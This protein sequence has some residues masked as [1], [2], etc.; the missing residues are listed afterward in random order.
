MNKHGS[1]HITAPERGV[2]LDMLKRDC[3]LKDIALAIEKDP[4]AVSREIR[5]RRLKYKTEDNFIKR[6]PKYEELCKRLTRFPF[7]C[8]GCK[9]RRGC[10]YKV[11]FV[12]K[13]EDAHRLYKRLLRDSRQGINLTPE[14]FKSLDKKIFDGVSKGQSLNHIVMHAD[15]FEVSKRTAYRYIEYGILSVTNVDLKRKVRLRKRKTPK[16]KKAIVDS[17]IRL[18]R[19]YIDYIRF[20]AKHPGVAAVQMDV[21]ES[22]K[23]FRTCLL[24]LH[25][26]DIRFMLIFLLPEKKDEYVTEVFK[27]LQTILTLEEYKKLFPVI[28][29][30]RGTE[31]CDPLSIEVHHETGEI[32]SHVFFCDPQASNQKGHIEKNHAIVRYVVPRGS[33]LSLLT[34]D[35]VT[36]MM[37]HVNSFGRDLIDTTPYKLF[38]AYYGEE[39]ARKLKV[40]A[41]DPDDVYLKPDLFTR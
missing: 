20:K 31:F 22:C 14:E 24:T 15:E 41:I 3:K 29:T 4:R 5:N 11:K 28:L 38:I 36:L 12:Y 9:K 7:V 13:P 6:S 19:L 35:D 33:N 17:K 16:K 21:I 40:R 37:N 34:E 2:I 39:I 26:I 1:K 10:R 32:L 8:D 25:F 18:N 23:P 27:Y 30:D